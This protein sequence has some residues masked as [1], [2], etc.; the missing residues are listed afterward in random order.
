MGD[1]VLRRCP[2]CGKG[3]IRP[4]A[5]EGR[6]IRHK[7]VAAMPIPA[8]FEIPTCDNCG[9]EWLDVETID[10]LQVVLDKQLD[11]YMKGSGCG[12]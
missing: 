1:K 2:E 9:S 12:D 8:D 7:T 6:T 5:M 4:W 11:K 3:I 10:R